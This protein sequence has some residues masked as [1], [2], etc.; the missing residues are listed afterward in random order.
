MWKEF[1][2]SCNCSSATGKGILGS[3][4]CSSSWERSFLVPVTVHL[5]WERGFLVPVTVHLQWKRCFLVP[6]TVHLQWERSFLVPVT[7]HNQWERGFL[8]L[9]TVHLH[10]KG[11]SW[12]PLTWTFFGLLEVVHSVS[13]KGTDYYLR[14]VVSAKYLFYCVFSLYEAMEVLNLLAV[15]RRM[16][17]ELCPSSLFPTKWLCFRSRRGTVLR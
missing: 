16:K 13:Q 9:V 4:N 5:Q 10:G 12:F 11:V 6:V 17:R 7:V 15:K 1:P 3:C 8:V 14:R 2:G